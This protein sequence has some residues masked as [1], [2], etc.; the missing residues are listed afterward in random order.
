ML[1]ILV[2]LF[3]SSI[4]KKTLFTQK[5]NPQVN[6]LDSDG[7]WDFLPFVPESIHQTIILFS[8][9]G[10]PD[11]Y[12]HLNGYSSHTLKIADEKGNFKYVKWHFKTDQSTNNLKTDKAAQLAGSDS[13]YAT[14]DLFEAIRRDDHSS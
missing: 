6:L 3:S 1:V 14:R 4:L 2:A 5:V 8:N 7:L 10:I 13:D 9:H 12:R 11:G